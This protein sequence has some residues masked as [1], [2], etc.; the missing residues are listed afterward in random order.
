MRMSDRHPGD[1][2]WKRRIARLS[3]RIVAAG[4]L[5]AVALPC[6]AADLMQTVP[7]LWVSATA[8]SLTLVTAAIKSK[9]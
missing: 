1:G 6:M 7:H 4:V 3:R 9:Q 8:L 2:R 5:C